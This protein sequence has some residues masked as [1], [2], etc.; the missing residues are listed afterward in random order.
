M[1]MLSGVMRAHAHEQVG[2]HDTAVEQLV[3]LV[4]QDAE[5]V[6]AIVSGVDLAP[7][8][9]KSLPAARARVAA[10]D[11]SYFNVDYPHLTC[12]HCGADFEITATTTAVRCAHC[13]ASSAVGLRPLLGA[14]A[15]FQGPFPGAQD[16]PSNLRERLLSQRATVIIPADLAPLFHEGR[17]RPG[18]VADAEEHWRKEV[19]LVAEGSEERSSRLMLLT[20]AI[21]SA[22][23]AP[24]APGRRHGRAMLET[25][26]RVIRDP[27]YLLRLRCTVA[28]SAA[29]A[30]DFEAAAAWLARCDPRTEELAAYSAMVLTRA[31]IANLRGDFA[32]TVR[33]L[34]PAEGDAPVSL[35]TRVVVA[36]IRAAALERLGREGDA[37]ESLMPILR[38][39]AD[40]R[41]ALVAFVADFDKDGEPSPTRSMAVALADFGRQRA[42]FRSTL[43][44]VLVVLAVAAYHAFA[45]R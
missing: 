43:L 17:L 13:G 23:A 3:L 34:G 19:R 31:R 45:A 33:L 22:E 16:L 26:L 8:C 42:I 24:G 12:D 10:I 25:A 21:W 5:A 6:D 7:M 11:A 4:S 32:E 44:A 36:L 2:N 14:A 30:G 37:V 9:A 29:Q 1:V 27:T 39:A 40:A 35:Q 41:S 38:W 28:T 20:S 18:R 15:A